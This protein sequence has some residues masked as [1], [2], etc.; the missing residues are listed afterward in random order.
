LPERSCSGHIGAGAAHLAHAG[1]GLLHV[2]VGTYML[3]QT[4]MALPLYVMLSSS[5]LLNRPSG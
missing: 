4:V 3:P 5:G 1:E 2:M